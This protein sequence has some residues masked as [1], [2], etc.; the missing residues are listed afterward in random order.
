MARWSRDHVPFPGAVF[1]EVVEQFIRDNALLTGSVRVGGRLVELSQA[2]GEVL[3]ALAERDS[4]IPPAA[5]EPLARLV[6]APDRRHELRLR[7]GHVTFGA[8]REA[9]R[10]TLPS[11]AEWIRAHSDQPIRPRRG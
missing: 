8:G 3:V 9:F 11:L 10:H 7:G 5:A 6:G 2:R 4:V 1:R